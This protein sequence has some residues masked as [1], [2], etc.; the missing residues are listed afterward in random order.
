MSAPNQMKATIIRDNFS[1]NYIKVNYQSIAN[2]MKALTP[3]EFQVWLY[4]AKNKDGIEWEISP[5]AACEEW[6]IK[7]SSFHKT[8]TT[9]K[10]MGYLVLKENST[11]RYWFYETPQKQETIF[12]IEKPETFQF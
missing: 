2:A 5:T 11:S 8:I 1:L 4:L 7:V 9:L 3:V 10:K 12:T 6:G